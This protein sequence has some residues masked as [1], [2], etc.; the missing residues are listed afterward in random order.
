MHGTLKTLTVIQA[1]FSYW[2]VTYRQRELATKLHRLQAS[3]I[4][5]YNK[6]TNKTTTGIPFQILWSA[7]AKARDALTVLVLD[8]R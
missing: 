5:K 6:N 4:T 2:H 8:S 7:T 3:M 1:G